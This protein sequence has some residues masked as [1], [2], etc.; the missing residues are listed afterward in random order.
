MKRA[1]F[2]ANP[3]TANRPAV[4]PRNNFERFIIMV[5]FVKKAIKFDEKKLPTLFQVFGI[6]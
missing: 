1:A 3:A 2:A 5:A 6:P 4:R